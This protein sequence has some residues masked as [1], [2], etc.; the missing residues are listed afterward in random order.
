MGRYLRC[1]GMPYVACSKWTRQSCQIPTGKEKVV[2]LLMR[3][4]LVFCEGNYPVCKHSLLAS[5][6]VQMCILFVLF[7]NICKHL[8]GREKNSTTGL[9][10]GSLAV[11]CSAGSWY[12]FNFMFRGVS[13]TSGNFMSGWLIFIKTN[14]TFFYFWCINDT[15][16]LF[17]PCYQHLFLLNFMCMY[18]IF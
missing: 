15:L 6:W 2:C 5:A 12:D 4:G 3:G 18:Y 10:V 14:W 1:Q 16:I 8:L 9:K 13:L 7:V 17:F 11:T